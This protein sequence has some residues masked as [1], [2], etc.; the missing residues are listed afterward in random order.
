MV[1]QAPG[2]GSFFND[3]NARS[4]CGSQLLA[5]K[6]CAMEYVLHG[7]RRSTTP[8]ESEG[9]GKTGGTAAHVRQCLCDHVRQ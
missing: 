2:P 9:S 1:D 8:A 7:C 6:R 5:Y 4:V 3:T